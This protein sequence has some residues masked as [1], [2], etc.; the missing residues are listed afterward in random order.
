MRGNTPRCKPNR[1][2]LAAST[3]S[4]V[5]YCDT[6]PNQTPTCPHYFP[7][8]SPPPRDPRPRILSAC[9]S[10]VNCSRHQ[11]Q[12]APSPRHESSRKASS[13]QVDPDR[14][15]DQGVWSAASEGSE[16]V[17]A[18]H[19]RQLLPRTRNRVDHTQ[20]AHEHC[21]RL[22]SNPRRTQTPGMTE[23]ELVSDGKSDSKPRFNSPRTA[24][25]R[26]PINRQTGIRRFAPPGDSGTAP[27]PFPVSA[28]AGPPG[29]RSVP[30]ATSVKRRDVGFRLS[31]PFAGFTGCEK[32]SRS[33]VRRTL[34]CAVKFSVVQH[35][36][37]LTLAI[38]LVSLSVP[39]RGLPAVANNPVR[40]T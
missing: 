22:P 23:P 7:H 33:T 13:T 2:C 1:T 15:E 11:L 3:R 18:S 12:C 24:C 20:P 25:R 40:Q 37:T 28:T 8:F 35:K 31:D 4:P 27:T 30:I 10:A 36:K 19:G 21:G 17:I 16:I 6:S 32:Y 29:E 34:E 14:A 38:S 39:I 5:R 9:M 26:M